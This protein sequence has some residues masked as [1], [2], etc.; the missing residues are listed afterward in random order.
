M[1]HPDRCRLVE[2]LAGQLTTST[3][4]LGPQG[5]ATQRSSMFQGQSSL[6]HQGPQAAIAW[7]A[8]HSPSAPAQR[9]QAEGSGLGRD[10]PSAPGSDRDCSSSAPPAHGAVSPGRAASPRAGGGLFGVRA[11]VLPLS[12][13]RTQ[14]RPPTPPPPPPPP[15]SSGVSVVAS[16][17]RALDAKTNPGRPRGGTGADSRGPGYAVGGSPSVACQSTP[18]GRGRALSGSRR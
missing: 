18:S 5:Q 8:T 17:Q 13:P 2:Q 1:V 10:G 7:P 4:P 12:G 15:P 11:T 6:G 3:W 14:P 9:A 16:S